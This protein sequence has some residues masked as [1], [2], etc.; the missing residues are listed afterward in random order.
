MQRG[1][2]HERIFISSRYDASQRHSR[3]VSHQS[4]ECIRRGSPYVGVR[5]GEHLDHRLPGGR[6]A[7]PRDGIDHE[8]AN[9]DIVARQGIDQASDGARTTLDEGL[10]GGVSPPGVIAIRQRIDQGGDY[11]FGVTARDEALDC[12]LANTPTRVAQAF[13]QARNRA[14]GRQLEQSLH[15][16]A[17][18]LLI[19]TR[20]VSIDARALSLLTNLAH[21]TGSAPLLLGSAHPSRNPARRV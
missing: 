19:G 18:Q 4:T 10:D 2:T 12:G 1:E 17:P 11:L 13:D 8:L 5:V 14:G 7:N 9:I 20:Q 21:A 3:V 15:R 6:V 16:Q